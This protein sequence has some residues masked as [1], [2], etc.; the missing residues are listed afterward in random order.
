MSTTLDRETKNAS[1]PVKDRHRTTGYWARGALRQAPWILLLLVVAAFVALPIIPLQ[2]KAFADGGAGFGRLLAM[3]DLGEIIV[4]TLVLGVG[5][6]IVAMF[7]GTLLALSMAAMSSRQRRYLSFLPVLPMVIPSVA[8]VVG[9]VFLLS[10]ENGYINTAIRALPFVN[11]TTGPFNVYTPVGI[12]LYTGIHLAAFV[13]L[14]VYSGLRNLGVDYGLAAKVNGASGFRTLMTVTLPLLRPVL[15]YAASVC[16]LLALGQFTAPLILGR[17]EGITVITTRMFEATLQYPVDF[18]LI[19]AMGTPLILIALALVALQRRLIGNQDRFIGQVTATEDHARSRWIGRLASTFVIS[20]SILSAV[21]PLLA[22]VFVALSPYWS[23]TLSL[24]NL[25]TKNFTAV[26][27]NNVFINSMTTSLWVS[28]LGVLIVIPIGMLIALGIYNKEK[29]WRPIPPILDFIANLPLSLPA[30]LLGFGYLF[31]FT[32]TPIGLY[33]TRISF[34]IAYVTLMVP[35]SARYQLATLVALGRQTMDASRVSGAGP[36]RTFGRIILPLSR[37]GIASSAAIIFVLLIHE[38]GVSL[39]LR[40]PKVNVMSVV[41]FEQ[42]DVGSYPQTA[43][44]ALVM[45][46]IT[47]LGVMGALI[48]GGSRALDRL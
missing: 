24:D 13:Y 18:N 12:V 35:Y 4:T 34:V 43:V 46:F 21:L 20:F 39:L 25:T 2:Q 22:L 44:I 31:A 37:S 10:P 3:P 5:A 6:L 27:S 28:A 7:L 36:L 8:H 17:R 45:T 40:S 42:Y 19:A 38:F 47:I 48:F 30:A 32:D 14:F 33:G 23:G 41:L 15:V 29:L 1:D 26:L 16:L 9:F 11:M